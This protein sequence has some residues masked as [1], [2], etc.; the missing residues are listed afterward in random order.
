MRRRDFIGAVAGSVVALP[1]A[2]RA[3][4]PVVPV[5][6][7][8]N[9]QS[10]DSYSYLVAA[11]RLGLK[12][13]GFIEGQNVSIEYR[14]ADGR[15]E[16]LP[17]MAIELVNRPV[18]ALVTGGSIW[19]TISAKASTTT[20]P[21]VFT[22]ASDPVKLGYVASLNRPGGNVTGVSFLAIEL[23]AKRL[24][25]ASQLVPKSVAIGFMGRPREPRYLANRK[26]MERIATALGRKTLFLD[27]AD[28]RDIDSAVANATR[29]HV[30]V[31]I[32]FND[33]FFNSNRDALI[34]SA[35]RHALPTVYE[36]RDYVTA[37]GLISY[38]TSI[39]AAY[40]Q[41]GVYVGRILKGEKP[42]DL[43]VVQSARFELVINLKAA[44]VL[45]LTIPQNLMVA[46]DEVIE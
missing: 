10:A 8:L 46:A 12:D 19:A 20:I 28:E 41:V 3:Q 5:V 42:A 22:T 26:E 27:V 33:P 31:L 44:K 7:L 25:L 30:G 23:T 15:D 13:E 14:W 45:G 2:A 17:E 40:R 24:E 11:L 38:G 35:A 16:R 34:A 6:G 9:G 21:I 43:P 1:L 4:Q 32:P 37:G 39:I 18:A 36:S 29:Q